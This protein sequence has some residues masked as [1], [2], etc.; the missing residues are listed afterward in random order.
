[1]PNSAPTITPAPKRTPA[2]ADAE[3]DD[4]L[5]ERDDDHRAVALGEVARFD[6]PA[7]DAPDDEPAVVDEQRGDPA[8]CARCSV[9]RAPNHEQR[10]PRATSSRPIA[11]LLPARA[12]IVP[13]A[14]DRRVAAYVQRAYD[15]VGD[16]EDQPVAAERVRHRQRGDQHRRHR[17]QQ[18]HTNQTLVGV[19]C[20]AQPRISRP[21]EP[22][23]GEDRQS[24]DESNPGRPLGY[25]AGHL[26]DRKHEHE[27]KEQL[28][29]RHALLAARRWLADRLD[30][31]WDL[32][33]AHLCGD[34][35]GASGAG[36]RESARRRRR[37][38]SHEPP[39]RTGRG[40]A[41]HH[42]GGAVLRPRLRL[43][44]HPALAPAARR[45]HL[46]R[47]GAHGVPA[48]WSSG[49]PGSTRPGWPTGSTRTRPPCASC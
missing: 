14:R 3:R 1:M 45:P 24:L 40:R 21:R 18:D 20:V 49:G 2:R 38:P 23:H 35:T 29:W 46:G 4:R 42:R 47:R 17:R 41:A 25:E 28:E 9:E 32:G 15:E 34:D 7:L 10:A 6:P 16:A 30:E 43:R 48:A 36:P 5:A 33:L 37:L 22:E 31:D 12:R 39:A 27:V 44:G 19:S 26:G 8:D 11:I 13:R